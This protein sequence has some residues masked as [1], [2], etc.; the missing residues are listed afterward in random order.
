MEYKIMKKL[1]LFP[2][3][4]ILLISFVCA[5]DEFRIKDLTISFDD[6]SQRVLRDGSTYNEAVEPGEKLEFDITL[7]NRFREEI[8]MDDIEITIRMNNITK[9]VNLVET[10]DKFDL[11]HKRTKTKSI[12]LDIP[13]DAD[14]LIKKA[15]ISIE[16]IDDNGTAHKIYWVVDIRIEDEKHDVVIYNTKINTSIVRCNDKIDLVVWLS[17]DGDF[18]ENDVVLEVENKELDVYQIYRDIEVGEGE[19]YAKSAVFNIGNVQKL[20]NFPL[21]L[22]SYYKNKI[23]DDIKIINLISTGCKKEISSEED[24]ETEDSVIIEEDE[25]QT[26]NLDYQEPEKKGLSVIWIGIIILAG[27]LVI[28]IVLGILLIRD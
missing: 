20:G 2:I 10:E 4:L 5:Y 17:N 28:I 9:G 13:S 15:E 27:I 7:E 8:D 21:E 14:E 24:N 19:K 25:K 22:R 6:D 12:K 26:I 16:G 18:D 3:I 23:L 1:L 11:N